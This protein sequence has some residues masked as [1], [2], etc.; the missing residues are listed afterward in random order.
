MKTT[1]THCTVVQ[2]GD[3]FILSR[4]EEQRPKNIANGSNED[5]LKIMRAVVRR[6]VMV[7]T[8]KT[9]MINRRVLKLDAVDPAGE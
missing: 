9:M 5:D 8:V 6:K 1:T 2:D 3:K 4:N 7:T